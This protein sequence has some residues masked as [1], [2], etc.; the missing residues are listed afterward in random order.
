[1]QAA[2][3]GQA[4]DLALGRRPEL[5]VGQPGER[6][7]DQRLEVAEGGEVV[8]EIGP[9]PPPGQLGRSLAFL[10]RERVVVERAQDLLVLVRRVRV[11][12]LPARSQQRVDLDVDPVAKQRPE[13]FALAVERLQ[14]GDDPE[15][16]MDLAGRVAQ[17]AVVARH[18]LGRQPG[19]LVVVLPLPDQVGPAVAADVERLG[20]LEPGAAVVGPDGHEGQLGRLAHEV[21]DQLRVMGPGRRVG[22][23]QREA[24]LEAAEG[25]VDPRSAQCGVA[26]EELLGHR[27]RLE[28]EQARRQAVLHGQLDVLLEPGQVGIQVSL[29]IDALGSGGC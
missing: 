17:D 9:A 10:G 4:G 24:G 3:L 2:H 1:M 20:V 21:R 5:F 27:A 12:V 26:A 18:V 16:G 22:Q 29:G 11:V 25:V 15:P 8:E 28:R 14:P 7:A 6:R 13:V 23:G 19:D